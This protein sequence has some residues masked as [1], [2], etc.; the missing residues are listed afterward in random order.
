MS[1]GFSSWR[2]ETPV[3]APTESSPLIHRIAEL[4]VQLSDAQ[5]QLAAKDAQLAAQAAV[6]DAHDEWASAID[7]IVFGCG[8]PAYAVRVHTDKIRGRSPK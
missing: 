6:L 4:K 7:S 2:R 3:S 5:K 8:G 1:F